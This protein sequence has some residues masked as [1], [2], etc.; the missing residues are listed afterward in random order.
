MVGIT[1]RTKYPN[2]ILLPTNENLRDSILDAN[3]LKRLSLD[4]TDLPEDIVQKLLDGVNQSTEKRRYDFSI[5]TGEGITNVAIVGGEDV[6]QLIRNIG[7]MGV[8]N[9]T[10]ERAHLHFYAVGIT[11]RDFLYNMLY[12]TEN[13]YY[14]LDPSRGQMPFHE[15]IGDKIEFVPPTE[16]SFDRK[17]GDKEVFER[18]I[19][20]IRFHLISTMLQPYENI[21]IKLM[22]R[23]HLRTHV[24]RYTPGTVVGEARFWNIIHAYL[25]SGVF[26]NSTYVGL[27]ITRKAESFASMIIY[28]GPTEVYLAEYIA[29]IVS[30]GNTAKEAGLDPDRAITIFSGL[31]VVKL[32][33]EIPSELH[34]PTAYSANRG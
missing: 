23:S 30:S 21:S 18:H 6:P 27:P 31:G 19:R 34:I 16:F 17:A 26:M 9:Y 11:G 22:G 29:D 33:Y 24:L 12:E 15:L 14:F 32:Q 2:L 20:G 8:F 28:R 4:D 25:E 1:T 10:S 5:E 13:P 3:L 7:E